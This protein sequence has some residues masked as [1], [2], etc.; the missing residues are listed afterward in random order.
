MG[1]PGAAGSFTLYGRN[2]PG[3]QP[4]PRLSLHG[5]PLEQLPLTLKLPADNPGK[6][7]AQWDRRIAPNEAVLPG[8]H[9]RVQGP[10]GWSNSGFIG[11]ATAPMAREKEPN[12]TAAKAQSLQLPCEVA[13]RFYPRDDA[14][15]FRFTAKKGEQFWI[16]VTSHRLEGRTDP[17]VLIQYDGRKFANA[18]DKTGTPAVFSITTGNANQQNTKAGVPFVGGKSFNT[19]P[20]DVLH[21]FTAPQ[22]GEYRVLLHD[23]YNTGDPRSV[24][25][26]AIRRARPDFRLL[27]IPMFPSAKVDS[28]DRSMA[29][30]PHSIL[31]RKGGSESIEVISFRRDALQADIH[32]SVEGLP[33]GVTWHP[34]VLGPARQ[35][36]AIVLTAAINAKYWVGDIQIIGRAKVKGRDIIR[37]AC[38]AAIGPPGTP[39][40]LARNFSVAV[41][42]FESLPVHIRAGSPAK[43]EQPRGGKIQIPIQV[44]RRNGFNSAIVLKPFNAPKEIPLKDLII[45]AG[46]T[47]AQMEFTLPGNAPVG[48]YSFHLRAQNLPVPYER[49]PDALQSAEADAKEVKAALIAIRKALEQANLMKAT[50]DKA[51]AAAKMKLAEAKKTATDGAQNPA[52]KAA[53]TG[54]LSTQKTQHDAAAQVAAKSAR[55]KEVE[56]ALKLAVKNVEAVKK[57]VAKKNVSLFLPSTTAS[58]KVAPSP[59]VFVPIKAPGKLRMKEKLELPVTI[60]RLYNYNG[61]VQL[62]LSHLAPPP[63]YV[64]AP[65]ITIPAGQIQGKLVLEAR[66]VPTAKLGTFPIKLTLSSKL[67][68]QTV[69]YSESVDLT[70][71][72]PA[73]PVTP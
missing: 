47:S 39:S 25:R 73:P 15:W 32:L 33:P 12:N 28:E 13:G 20:L 26:L 34:A 42:G 66:F 68:G 40:R 35:S 57:S 27:A 63:S 7:S 64:S 71:I 38:P 67:N 50:A 11:L 19:A 31:L 23:L 52:F 45:P 56:E 69:N 29:N 58:F 55:M 10:A 44:T 48:A 37:Q 30:Q 46:Q 36:T 2:L 9:H 41:S 60:K 70:T 16:E 24:Y 59:V 62:T 72:I 22:D 49:N 21:R 5:Q 1:Q 65:A 51:V 14:D 43:V 61:P 3:G 17:H 8:L 54:L 18:Q 6:L 53:E 4:A